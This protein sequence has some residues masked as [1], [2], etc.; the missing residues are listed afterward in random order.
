MTAIERMRAARACD[1][2]AALDAA[3]DDVAGMRRHVPALEAALRCDDCAQAVAAAAEIDGPA[4]RDALVRMV[5]Q[6]AY[7]R[8]RTLHTGGLSA[9]EEAFEALGWPDPKAWTKG[10][11][12]VPGCDH[13]AVVGEPTPDGGYV[14]HCGRHAPLFVAIEKAAP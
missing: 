2:H 5:E 8:K 1:Y 12:E 10:F 6:F 14:W 3:F 7:R 9:L 4:L 13:E 11:C